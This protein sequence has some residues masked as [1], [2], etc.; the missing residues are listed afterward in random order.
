MV[1]AVAPVLAVGLIVLVVV[2]DQIVQGEPIVGGDEIDRC[3][4]APALVVEQVGRAHDAGGELG[5]LPAIAAPERAHVVTEP[6]IPLGPARREAAELVAAGADVPRLGDQFDLA[7][8]RVLA[9]RVQEAARRV[10]ALALASQNRGQVEAEAVHVHVLHPVAQR[11]HH[12][13][14]CT[15]VGQVEGVAGAGVVDVVARVVGQAIVAGVVDALERQRRAQLV[16]FGG[17]VV[18]HVQDHLQPGR[19]HPGHHLLELGDGVGGQQPRVRC[20]EGQGVIAPIV[21]QATLEQVLV[22]HVGVHGQQ[23]QRSGA[24]V[25][26]VVQQAVV[27]ERGER[28]PCRFGYLRMQHRQPAHVGFVDHRIFPGH[29]RRT[30]APPGERRIDHRALGHERCAVAFVEAQVLV[31]MAHGV[32]E[33][34]RRPLQLAHHLPGVGVQQQLVAVETVPGLGRVRAVHAIAVALARAGVGQV[35]VPYLVGVLGQDDPLHLTPPLVEQAQLHAGGMAAVE[36]EVDAHPV[37]G[38]AQ[39]KRATCA[40]A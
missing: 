25:P 10:E 34:R 28:A 11:I 15:G 30:V 17:V 33:Q 19:M 20:E 12:H 23:F 39:R 38:R 13:A 21:A 7:Q 36:R 26:E 14:Q 31:T 37:P 8:H 5:Q 1:A 18:D 40:Q 35:A 16:A 27:L 6:V 32:A 29:A 2:A 4:R 22:V 24:Q 9:H 3:R